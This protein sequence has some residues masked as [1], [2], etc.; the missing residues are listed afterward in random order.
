[1]SHDTP[2]LQAHVRDRL[3]TRY[4]KRLRAA[5]RLPAVIYGHGEQPLAVSLDAKETLRH[6]HQGIHVFNISTGHGQETCLV[7]DLQ[8]GHLGDDV[9]HLDLSRV[10]LDEQVEV[11]VHLHFVGAPAAAAKAGVVLTHVLNEV[12]VRCKVRDIPEE[13]RVDLEHM[14]GD[15]FTVADLAMPAGCTAVTAASSLV[16]HLEFVSE[17]AA[18]EAAA[19]P[20][21]ATPEV[22]ARK[23]KEGEGS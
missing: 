16:A 10:N 5:G 19:A 12:L 7:K 14:A 6:L 22:I 20:A 8:F 21:A 3:G 18:G 15:A 13:I 23:E 1:M 4:S 17:A 2:T 11:K 9:I